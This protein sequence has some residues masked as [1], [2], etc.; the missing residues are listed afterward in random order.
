MMLYSFPNGGRHLYFPMSFFEEAVQLLMDL[1]SFTLE[2]G[3]DTYQGSFLSR[4]PGR[5][6]LVFFPSRGN[7][8]VYRTTGPSGFL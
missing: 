7:E 2:V 1:P 5:F 4:T 6:R 8:G 3:M